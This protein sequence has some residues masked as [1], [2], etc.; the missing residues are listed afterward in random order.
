MFKPGTPIRFPIR[1]PQGVLLVSQGAIVTGRLHNL[2][3]TRGI[4][5]ELQATLN[6]LEGEPAGLEIPITKPLFKIGRRPTATCNCPAT[7]SAATIARFING[8]SRCC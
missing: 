6:L 4:T 8:R 3:E 5:L 7:L 1:D 2:L